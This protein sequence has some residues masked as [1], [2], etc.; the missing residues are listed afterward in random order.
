MRRKEERLSL[1]GHQV[2]YDALIIRH[3]IAES[4]SDK[5]MMSSDAGHLQHRQSTWNFE[6][7]AS[8]KHKALEEGDLALNLS[9]NLRKDRY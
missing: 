9:F 1:L 8:R 3:K 5:K 7:V 6:S 4:G 2:I